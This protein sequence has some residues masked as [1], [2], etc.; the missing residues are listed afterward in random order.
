MIRAG[1]LDRIIRIERATTTVDASGTPQQ[2]W[3]PLATMRAELLDA[4]T[5]EAARS[6]GTSTE[7]VALFRI[8]YLDGITVADR[9][10]YEGQAFDIKQVKE[11]GRRRALELR[12]E[13]VGP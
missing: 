11:V 7:A 3:A 2:S 12:T 4:T 5:D 1:K 13:R 10:I 8:R 9:V 6:F